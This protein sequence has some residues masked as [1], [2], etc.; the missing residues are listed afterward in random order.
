MSQS[1][2]YERVN[3]MIDILGESAMFHINKTRCT[4]RYRVDRDVNE[5]VGGPET[6]ISLM[7]AAATAARDQTLIKS[8]KKSLST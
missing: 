1:R 7:A 8:D 6:M 4:N 5:Y 2:M 3:F